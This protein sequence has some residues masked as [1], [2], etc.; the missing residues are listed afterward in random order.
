VSAAAVGLPQLGLRPPVFRVGK[1]F[2]HPV[3]DLLVIG[4]V[5]SMVLT[6]PL[7]WR[8]GP[9]ELAQKLELWLPLLVLLSNSAHFAA[10]TV[11]L[12]TKPFA[13]REMPFLT[14][15]FPLLTLLAL[16]LA[17]VFA[18]VLG[19]PLQKL[20]L[21]WSPYHYAAQAY[22]L[23]LMYAYRSGCSLSDG[24]KRLV[25]LA[26]LL[27]FFG[28]VLGGRTLLGATVLAEPRVIAVKVFAAVAYV[29]PLVV[30]WRLLWQRRPGLPLISVAVLVSNTFW[31]FT[32]NQVGAFAWATVFHGLQYLAIV[33]IFHVKDRL[34]LPGNTHGW[35]WH[36][37][38][39][40]L[41]CLVFGYL[42]FEIWPFAYALLGFGVA[43]SMLLVA[44]V[45]NLHHF[46]VDAFIWK[47][48]QS[49]NYQIVTDAV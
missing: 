3:F 36:A 45:I 12:Y 44:A 6:P 35:A 10:S 18:N 47:L 25:R 26:C 28:A 27:P 4:S 14:M 16:T 2:V 40:Y 9:S 39:F 30:C 22:G 46:I 11:R 37:A 48:R 17:I 34:R 24:D 42:I 33:T 38:T 41:T 31:L 21:T 29:L 1:A 8:G 7:F 15:G 20:Y 5:L 13:L 49:P 19:A 43:E 32:L 23:S